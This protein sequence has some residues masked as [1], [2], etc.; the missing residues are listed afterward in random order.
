LNPFN[1]GKKLKLRRLNGILR[2]TG[3]EKILERINNFKNEDPN[4]TNDI[5]GNIL[6]SSN[7]DN[8][9]LEL[10]IDDFVTFFIAGQETTANTLGFC[11]LELGKN[12]QVLEKYYFLL[13]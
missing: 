3:R 4:L 9:D 13:Q 2:N 7:D 6:K 5:L 1:I 11:F 12:P 8:F 10:M